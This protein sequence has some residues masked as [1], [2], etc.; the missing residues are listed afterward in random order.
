MKLGIIGC[1][2]IANFH[3]PAM[4]KVG[5][6]ISAIA[7]RPG[8]FVTVKKFAEKFNVK[9]TFENP[10]DLIKSNDWDALLICCPVKNTVE[11]L[12][13]AARYKKP[14][15]T[16]KPISSDFKDLE[17]LIKYKN[18]RVAFNRRFYNNADRARKFLIKN[19]CSLIKVSIPESSGK[20]NI[21]FPKKLPLNSY[22]NS[23]HIFDLINH[24]AGEVKW[25]HIHQIKNKKDFI[26]ILAIGTSK[27]NHHIL[28]DN[29]YN[30]SENFSINIVSSAQRLELSPIE[31]ASFYQGMNI[32]EPSSQM[33]LRVYRPILKKQYIED[34]NSNYKPG[35]YN[36][37]K[38]FM[39]FCKGK[40]SKSATVKETYSTL[41]VIQML[42]ED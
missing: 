34:G 15:L 39:S 30:S 3:L 5:F 12:N 35:F 31:I 29:S 10:Y 13:I 37:A 6:K 23:V 24:L 11:Y 22:I 42:A 8:G 28:L 16:E 17:H 38:D 4:K 26:S 32:T 33:P 1:G 14:I 20:K 7:G 36:Q 2:H 9:K 21:D 19:K 40:I 41:K 18:I 27:K 25:Q